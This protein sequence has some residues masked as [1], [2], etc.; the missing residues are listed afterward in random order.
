[1]SM[2]FAS[3]RPNLPIFEFNGCNETVENQTQLVEKLASNEIFG[4]NWIKK[5]GKIGYE[6]RLRTGWK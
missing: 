1:M 5:F 3:I 4:Q 2:S 6:M